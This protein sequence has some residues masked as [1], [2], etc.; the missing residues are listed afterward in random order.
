MANQTQ[1]FVHTVSIAAKS[2][3]QQFDAPKLKIGEVSDGDAAE[4][5]A[6]FY[7][8]LEDEERLER[9]DHQCN[10]D[11]DEDEPLNA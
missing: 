5:L 11:E 4:T 7:E 3:I 10:D 1:C 2:I 9:E 8:G 6:A